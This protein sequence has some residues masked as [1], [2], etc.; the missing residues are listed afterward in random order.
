MIFRNITLAKPNF[1]L[2]SLFFR[3][4]QKL[5][6]PWSKLFFYNSGRDAILDGLNFLGLKKGARILL[7]SYICSSVSNSLKQAGFDLIFVDVGNDLVMPIDEL[8]EIIRSKK[9]KGVLLV[10]YFGFL[11]EENIKIADKL[12]EIDVLVLIDRCHSAI[13]LNRNKNYWNTA[14]AIILSIRKTILVPDGGALILNSKK[15]IIDSTLQSIWYKDLPFLLFCLLEWIIYIVGWPNIYGYKVAK[16]RSL[17]NRKNNSLSAFK[18]PYDSSNAVLRNIN[19][20]NILFNQLCNT[21]RLSEVAKLRRDNYN[22]LSKIFISK[23]FTTLFDSLDVDVVPQVLP[24]IVHQSGMVDFLRNHGVG[25]YNWP[26]KEL[27]EEVLSLSKI[28]INS[29]NFNKKVVCLPIHQSI[30]SKDMDRIEFILNQWKQ[31]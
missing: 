11:A 29:I 15:N 26:G 2:S 7:P 10:D 16:I 28:H 20:S 24:I 21:K 17:I 6:S 22:K 23:G 12:R 1:D 30:N 3:R 13:S 5:V 18:F 19:P 14:D 4:D 25:A 31:V 27:P 8:L 9:S